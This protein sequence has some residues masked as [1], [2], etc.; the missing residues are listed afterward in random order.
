MF[1]QH[2]KDHITYILQLIIHFFVMFNFEFGMNLSK[3][4]ETVEMDQKHQILE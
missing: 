4:P 1:I 2:T 3:I